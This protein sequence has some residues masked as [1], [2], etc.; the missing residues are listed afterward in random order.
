[1]LRFLVAVA[2]VLAVLAGGALIVA[3]VAS[4]VAP[5]AAKLE[6][7]WARRA[8]AG[9]NTGML[10][11]MQGDDPAADGGNGVGAFGDGGGSGDGGAA[12]GGDGG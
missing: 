6:A 5:L 8:G 3:A 10:A 2:A 11:A 12:G 1:M 9:G 7:R 4:R